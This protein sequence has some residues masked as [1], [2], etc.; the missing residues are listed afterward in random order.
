MGEYLGSCSGCVYVDSTPENNSICAEC[1]GNRYTPAPHVLREQA[2]KH[3]D[4]MDAL[5]EGLKLIR[6]TCN[7]YYDERVGCSACPLR[8]R[9]IG[10]SSDECG[11][12]EM[13]KRWKLKC[14][15]EQDNRL[16][17]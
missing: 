6:E 8:V 9:T 7:E 11:I 12:E 5:I 2:R 14:D 16:F 10:F 4:G 3:E 15:E 13:P 1:F 17:K